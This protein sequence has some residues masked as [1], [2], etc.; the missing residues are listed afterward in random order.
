MS[1]YVYME[2]NIAS[3]TGGTED[4]E[5]ETNGTNFFLA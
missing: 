3:V 4:W 5:G 2:I 1:I